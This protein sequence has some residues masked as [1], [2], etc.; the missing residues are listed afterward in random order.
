VMM[1][2]LPVERPRH[3]FS[4]CLNRHEQS[5]PVSVARPP[6]A[7][8]PERFGIITKLSETTKEHHPAGIVCGAL[9]LKLAV[10][11]DGTQHDARYFLEDFA[12]FHKCE[13]TIELRLQQ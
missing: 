4:H 13:R 6:R 10:T 12:A 1:Q 9:R 8:G 3:A 11:I 7:L 2:G 5:Q